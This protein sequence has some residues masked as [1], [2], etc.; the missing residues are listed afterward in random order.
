MH[1]FSEVPKD[2]EDHM[3]IQQYGVDS[4]YS[5]VKILVHAILAEDKE[6]L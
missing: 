4:I 1:L 6:S 5:T 3:V 2:P